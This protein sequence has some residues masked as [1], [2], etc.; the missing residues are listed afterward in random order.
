MY[1]FSIKSEKVLI[2]TYCSMISTPHS[3]GGD[4]SK[5]RYVTFEQLKQGSSFYLNNDQCQFKYS[6]NCSSCKYSHW[7]TNI[8]S[9]LSEPTV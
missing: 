6:T 8:S 2:S 5:L 1:S 7:S 9:V 3:L 4:V